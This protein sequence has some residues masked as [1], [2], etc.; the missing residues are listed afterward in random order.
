M[1]P[2]DALHWR[3]RLK[4]I[5]EHTANYPQIAPN[6][7][8]QFWNWLKLVAIKQA[9]NLLDSFDRPWDMQSSREGAQKAGSLESN[10]TSKVLRSKISRKKTEEPLSMMR[11]NANPYQLRKLFGQETLAQSVE[12]TDSMLQASAPACRFIGRAT[13]ES[14]IEHLLIFVQAAFS[15]LHARSLE[16]IHKASRGS[17]APTRMGTLLSQHCC[18]SKKFSVKS[19]FF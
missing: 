9:N 15:R 10:W 14:Q 12:R 19:H 5:F 4:F 7:S 11:L 13:G 16:A 6:R 18:G 1:P 8:E 3:L 17:P 2:E